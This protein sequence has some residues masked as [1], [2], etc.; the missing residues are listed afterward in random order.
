MMDDFGIVA[1]Q[2]AKSILNLLAVADG[3][4]DGQADPFSVLYDLWMHDDL[5][6]PGYLAR[7][8]VAA[9]LVVL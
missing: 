7:E 8:K 6:L 1:H 9:S 5:K 3:S 2:M 4:G